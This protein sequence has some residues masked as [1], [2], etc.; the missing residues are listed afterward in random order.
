[1]NLGLWGYLTILAAVTESV[2]AACV[3]VFIRRME[4]RTPGRGQQVDVARFP[5]A[6]LSLGAGGQLTV[7]PL[8]IV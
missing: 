3:F 2:F 1:M 6:V 7:I 8:S 4:N 5:S